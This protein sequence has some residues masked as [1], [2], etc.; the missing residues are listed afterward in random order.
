MIYAAREHFSV[1]TP[2]NIREV[3]GVEVEV[4]KHNGRPFVIPLRPTATTT[5]LL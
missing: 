1:L 2:E 5:S 4:S 3:Y